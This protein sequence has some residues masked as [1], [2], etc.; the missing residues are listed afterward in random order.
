MY[1]FNS[2][3]H[4]ILHRYDLMTQLDKFSIKMNEQFL[5][6]ILMI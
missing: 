2:N 5:F 3:L 6:V 4:L 1:Y